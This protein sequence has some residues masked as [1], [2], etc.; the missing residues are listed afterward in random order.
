[1]EGHLV[2]HAIKHNHLNCTRCAKWYLQLRAHE[3]S[4]YGHSSHREHAASIYVFCL[5]C[6]DQSAALAAI[7]CL[8]SCS[9]MCNQMVRYIG[10]QIY[11]MMR[12][13]RSSET[14]LCNVLDAAYELESATSW[15]S[16]TKWNGNN[17]HVFE[18]WKYG[19]KELRAR[20]NHYYHLRNQLSA[21]DRDIARHPFSE[22]A[23]N[24]VMS[25]LLASCDTFDMHRDST[26]ITTL[27]TVALLFA[28]MDH[29][30]RISF[31]EKLSHCQPSHPNGGSTGHDDCLHA[32]P[33]T[34]SQ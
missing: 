34:S 1:M 31:Q 2:L 16:S 27:G 14:A 13:A 15:L 25:S 18:R 30:Q 4:I 5:R 33:T 32:L 20:L 22:Y 6:I 21:G 29:D 10:Q 7:V 19:T 24:R 8:R 26:M 11:V 3:R 28:R 12:Q 9:G 17:G 23:S